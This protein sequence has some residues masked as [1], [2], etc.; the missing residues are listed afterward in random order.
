MKIVLG[1]LFIN[2]LS[3]DL[4]EPF[5]IFHAQKSWN[6]LLPLFETENNPPLHFILLHFWVKW[7]GIEPF[8][9]RSLSLIFSTLT[10]P[11]LFYI[12]RILRSDRMGLVLMALFTCSNFH[13]SFG[14][15]AR[16]YALFVLIFT[17]ALLVLL[18]IQEQSTM[19]RNTG[20]ALLCAGLFYTHYIAL[21]AIPFMFL[22]QFIICNSK[23]S[24]KTWLAFV[25]SIFVFILALSPFMPIF[26]E[27]LSHVQEA[28]TWVVRPHWTALYGLINKFLNG[29]FVLL[30]SLVILAI[31]YFQNKTEHLK[32][33]SA[34][35]RHPIFL[36]LGITLGIYLGAFL[37]SLFNNSSVFLDRYLFFL[38]IGLFILLA[39]FVEYLIGK[40]MKF[41]WL[42]II[43]LIF[44]FNPLKTHNRESDALVQYAA[45]FEGSYIITPP[46]YDLTFV[47][48]L[49]QEL[50][51]K[52]LEGPD[53]FKYSIYPIHGIHEI[54]LETI[55]KPIV[56]IDAGAQ[57][58]Y[59]EQKLKSDLS[60]LFELKQHREFLGG[61]E[62]MVFE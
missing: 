50:F 57:F 36:I 46:H 23:H 20:F 58:L 2:R 32:W 12:G 21:V 18:K 8:A 53:L 48:H 52:I 60:Q 15:E 34:H 41:S 24:T 61:Y 62:V 35:F 11:I 26:L 44:G 27:R 56:L 49:D 4:D 59:G 37:L 42:P 9:V 14:I 31:Y 40:K 45:S 33:N 51:S 3:I 19:I 25:V 16:G 28:G 17:L 13:H 29:P 47:Y 55:K 6:D 43:I 10:L 38:S 54:D 7:F 22:A 5:S 30:S 39:F 1:F